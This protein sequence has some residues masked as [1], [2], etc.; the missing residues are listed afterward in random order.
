[1][2]M[3]IYVCLA[4]MAA[5]LFVAPAASSAQIPR[6]SDGKP[7]FNGI[8]DR[9]RVAD[10]MADE[11]GDKCGSGSSGCSHKSAGKVALTPLGKQIMSEPLL[12]YTEFCFP[13]G[14]MRSWQTE[15]PVEIMQTPQRLAILFEENTVFKVVPTD[16]RQHPADVAP[17]WDGNS[18]GRYEGDTLV[19]DTI[20]F[21]GRTTLDRVDHA[22]STELHLIERFRMIDADHMAYDVTIEDPKLY[23]APIK[24][25]RVFVRMKGEELL[26]NFCMDNNRD[27]LEGHL[28]DEI[29]SPAFKKYME[30]H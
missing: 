18:V 15:N 11:K 23:T 3:R 26:E 17:S 30:A 1:M 21:N 22:S 19:I 9:S 29:K 27:L 4:V 28:Q 14:Y 8:W 5:T 12:H 2:A 25:S 16:G 10:V 20:G 7:D 6:L 24:N 13:W